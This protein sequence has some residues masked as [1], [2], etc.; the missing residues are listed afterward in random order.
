MQYTTKLSVRSLGLDKVGI[1]ELAEKAKGAVVAVA[2]F[3]GIAEKTGL[4]DR[5]QFGEALFFEG[6]FEGVNLGTREVIRSGKL[7]LPDVAS[8]ILEGM[9]VTGQEAVKNKETATCQVQ[10]AFEI[11]AQADKSAAVGYKFSASPLVDAKDVPD[12]LANLRGQLPKLPDKKDE[13]PVGGKK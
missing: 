3:Y 13:K 2:R 6:Q 7:F 5:S 10:F 8:N 11:N 1:R 12:P 9:V 4:S